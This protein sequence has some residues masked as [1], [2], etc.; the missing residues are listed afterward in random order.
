MKEILI[1][2]AKK[3][4]K[5]L[6]E[7][8]RNEEFSRIAVDKGR[9]DYSIKM[10]RMAEDLILE[11][12]KE[13][14]IKGKVV[15]EE[16]GEISLGASDYTLYIDPLDGTLNYSRGI[17]HYATSIGVEKDNEIILGVICDPNV[18]ELFVAEKNKGAFLNGKRIKVSDT[19]ELNRSIINVLGRF[20]KKSP[21]LLDFYTKL[22]SNSVIRMPMSAV[23]SLAYTACGRS[24]ASIGFGP[25]KWDV[26]AGILLVKEAGGK[27]TNVKGEDYNLHSEDLVASNSTI[28]G[29]I[30]EILAIR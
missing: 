1:E 18:D 2:T 15:A 4:G 10:D 7:N 21:Q 3:A 24:D 27:V 28:H 19:T 29:K 5:L 12:L 9:F 8:F 23:L 14:G 30:L 25:N 13:N 16:T 26:A 11:S 20:F 6:L 22:A 17:P